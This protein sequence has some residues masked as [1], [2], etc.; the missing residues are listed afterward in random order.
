MMDNI[1][2]KLENIRLQE[3]SLKKCVLLEVSYFV[4][5]IHEAET[6]TSGLRYI[7]DLTF[8]KNNSLILKFSG[9]PVHRQFNGII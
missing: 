1:E 5:N 7:E 9:C 4:R 2:N 6:V 8:L 3:Y